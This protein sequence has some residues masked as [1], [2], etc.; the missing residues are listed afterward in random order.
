MYTNT[1][2][3]ALV[4]LLEKWALIKNYVV[5]INSCLENRTQPAKRRYTDNLRSEVTSGVN[6]QEELRQTGV[7]KTGVK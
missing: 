1:L 6:W 2:F 5:I 4:L 3:D 7:K